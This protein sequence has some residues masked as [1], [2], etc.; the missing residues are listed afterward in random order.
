MM[1]GHDRFLELTMTT[2]TVRSIEREANELKAVPG[3]A[4]MLSESSESG[5][6]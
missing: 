2:Q 5:A 1:S 4:A 6:P 3:E